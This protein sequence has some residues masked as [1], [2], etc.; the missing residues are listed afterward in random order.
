MAAEKCSHTELVERVARV[1]ALIDLVERIKGLEGYQELSN[2]RWSSHDKVH[3]ALA[4]QLDSQAQEYERRLE[5]LN[6][7]SDKLNKMQATY[8]PR[9][10]YDQQNREQNKSIVNLET[11]QSR[12]S[13]IVGVIS[14]LSA[15]IGAAVTKLFLR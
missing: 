1:E 3:I 11:F 14:V 9:E 5:N 7:E 10:V 4:K 12:F 15:I 6:N 2:E 8:I 13:L